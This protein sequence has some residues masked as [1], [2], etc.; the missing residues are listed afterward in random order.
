MRLDL[1]PLSGVPTAESV[2]ESDK[3]LI[4][5]GGT[6]KQ[7][8]A[9]NVSGGGGGDSIVFIGCNDETGTMNSTWQEIYDNFA[10]GKIMFVR[11]HGDWGYAVSIVASAVIDDGSYKVYTNNLE[12]AEGIY[13]WT[14][15]ST[16]GYPVLID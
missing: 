16:S 3:V 15:D 7:T 11:S 10:D 2:G 14:T 12:Q 6:I 8:A 1:I 9:S 5:S 4:N 13:A